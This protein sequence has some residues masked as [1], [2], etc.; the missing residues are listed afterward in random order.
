[1][2]KIFNVLV[3]QLGYDEGKSIFEWYCKNYNLDIKDEA[4]ASI[5]REVL[6]I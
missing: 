5:K 2:R 1:M 6:G 4:P 3:K